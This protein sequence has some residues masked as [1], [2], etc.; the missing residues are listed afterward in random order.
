M[1]RK[2]VVA[3]RLHVVPPSSR[4][5]VMELERTQ[6]EVEIDEKDEKNRELQDQLDKA[7]VTT[8]YL[9]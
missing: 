1:P 8:T 5:Q 6:R 7:H 3:K 4:I 2:R 9:Q